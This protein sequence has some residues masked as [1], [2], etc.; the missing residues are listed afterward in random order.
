M[1]GLRS[2]VL[3]VVVV[4]LVLSA[5]S[6]GGGATGGGGSA[7]GGASAGGGTSG[8]SDVILSR[9]TEGAE[10]QLARDASGVIHLLVAPA[11]KDAQGHASARYARCASGCDRAESWSSGVVL[12]G[13]LAGT[14]KLAVQPNGTV[15]AAYFLPTKVTFGRCSSAC[16]SSSGWSYEDVTF[17]SGV[18]VRGLPAGRSFAVTANGERR[19]LVRGTAGT[20]LL[21]ANA[22]ANWTVDPLLPADV[23]TAALVAANEGTWLVAATANT[24]FTLHAAE[25]TTTCAQVASWTKA[26]V[27][28][29][30]A[31]RVGLA[32]GDDGVL[33]AAYTQSVGSADALR[34]ARCASGCGTA[35]GWSSVD[36]GDGNDGRGGLDIAVRT[37]GTVAIVGA[38]PSSWAQ[39]ANVRRCASGCDSAA[40]WPQPTVINGSTVSA[41]HPTQNGAAC[42]E[43]STMR[44]WA[45]GDGVQVVPSAEGFQ[46]ATDAISYARCLSGT[47]TDHFVSG[48][49]TALFTR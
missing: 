39:S 36:V 45:V 18:G 37:D 4:V 42:D 7:G 35:L 28:P 3:G 31:Y 20:T 12:D 30:N 40:G 43:A 2:T 21:L 34:Y 49:W 25:C 5:C 27:G 44:N 1:R 17:P 9:D 38:T 26:V 32:R 16:T 46:L 11:T 41:T 8:G 15:H 10:P 33:H 19:V 13:V 24:P 6:S 22:G 14:A 23:G 48:R 29:S 47:N